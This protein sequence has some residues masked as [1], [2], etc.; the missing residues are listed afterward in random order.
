VCEGDR[1]P[2]ILEAALAEKTQ[3]LGIAEV[4][5]MNQLRQ[6]LLWDTQ[7]HVL[8][9]GDRMLATFGSR[10]D[11]AATLLERVSQ[12]T[13]AASATY[14]RYA[15]LGFGNGRRIVPAAI[16]SSPGNRILQIGA[17]LLP[18]ANEYGAN[19]DQPLCAEY[20]GPYVQGG[21]R[22]GAGEPG[23]YTAELVK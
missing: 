1:D 15:A 13:D 4:T 2:A 22:R 20:L 16:H 12:D 19:G 23:Y 21:K 8:A 11:E 18:A 14:S 10:P 9:L 5:Q 7:T 6:S 17:F 3:P